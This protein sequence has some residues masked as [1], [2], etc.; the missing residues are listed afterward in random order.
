L[1]GSQASRKIIEYY[2]G[3]IPFKIIAVTANVMKEDFILYR[4]SG[5]VDVLSKPVNFKMLSHTLH[6]HLS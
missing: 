4:E 3:E 6:K 5:M 2:R 1:N